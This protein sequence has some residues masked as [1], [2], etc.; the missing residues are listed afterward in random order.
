V[1]KIDYF[2]YRLDG[3]NPYHDREGVLLRYTFNDGSM[4]YGDCH[5]W[6]EFGDAPLEKQLWSLANFQ[7]TP[8][9][10]STGLLAQI[11]AEA[12]SR[13]VSLF[14][15]IELPKSHWHLTQLT[16]DIPDNFTRVKLKV[17]KNPPFEIQAL[18]R[19]FASL[20]G[21]V[22]VR[23]DFNAR[24]VE[25]A[26]EPY[27]S[28]LQSNRDKIDYIEDPVHYDRRGWLALQE[29]MGRSL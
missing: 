29:R 14:S 21:N 12:R 5:P 20:P 27:V 28:L 3:K 6:E 19:F 26:F 11:D 17:G 9:T 25:S 7:E 18:P 1:V 16:D 2:P 4:G 24:L 23:L 22:K 15:E 8:L 13:G 10:R